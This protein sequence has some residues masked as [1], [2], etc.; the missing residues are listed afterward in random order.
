MNARLTHLLFAPWSGADWVLPIVARFLFAALL[1]AHF[2]TS[3]LTK[4]GAGFTGLVQ[5]DAGA[6]VQIFPRAMEAVGYDPA[7][8]PAW[9]HIVAHLA[10][11][12]EFLLPALILLGLLARPAALGMILFIIVMSVTDLLGHR[13]LEDTQVLGAWF[14][15]APDG[16]VLDQ[17]MLWLFLLLVILIKGA[18]PL[19][20]DRLITRRA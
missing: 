15:R 19:S 10:T 11:Y 9:T 17:R 16:I 5:L 14:D 2:W 1:T 7:A 4:L 12:A 8:L 3:G 18:G 20:L 13:R 6:Y